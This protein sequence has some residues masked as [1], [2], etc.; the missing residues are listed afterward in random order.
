MNPEKNSEPQAKMQAVSALFDQWRSTRKK[1]GRI[2][3][4][5]W[6]VAVGLSPPYSTYE[7]SKALRLDF[8][9]LKRRIGDRSSRAAPSEF[10]ELKV[11]RL[12]STGQCVMEVRS[13]AGFELKI[14][15]DAALPSQCM[16]LLSCFLDH[17]R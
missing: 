9:E 11:E 15:T 3:E 1:R 13:P 4:N 8:K 6:Q 5:L 10:V 7:I 16:H 17:G 14:Q 2:S 12:F